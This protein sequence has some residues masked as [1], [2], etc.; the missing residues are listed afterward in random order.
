[1]HV[2]DV[3]IDH[4]CDG[5]AGPHH[6]AAPQALSTRSVVMHSAKY[7]HLVR[8]LSR[9]QDQYLGFAAVAVI[10]LS[11]LGGAPA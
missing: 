2:L 11:P 8:S 1:M 3:E 5:S 6:V 10:S 9:T 4:A 7:Q